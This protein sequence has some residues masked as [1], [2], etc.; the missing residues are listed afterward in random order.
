MGRFTI[1]AVCD[2][3]HEPA[4]DTKV[5]ISYHDGASD[6]EWTD[7]QGY[8]SFSLPSGHECR[9]D[10][11]IRDNSFRDYRLYSGR[12]LKFPVRCKRCQ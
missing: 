10:I 8:A 6:S 9:G 12:E 4:A 11:Y 1:H 3:H 5:S 7:S 2:R